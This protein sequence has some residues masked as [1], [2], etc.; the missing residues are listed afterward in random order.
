ME[1]AVALTRF[2]KISVE[3]LPE[4][5][6]DYRRSHVILSSENPQELAPLDEVERRYIQHVLETV[7]GNRTVAAR[8]LG[9][10]RKTLYR[11]LRRHEEGEIDAGGVSDAS[12]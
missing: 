3:D 12:G 2:E 8:V 7:G 4:R 9:L 10:D 11:K 6:R 1:R 5:I